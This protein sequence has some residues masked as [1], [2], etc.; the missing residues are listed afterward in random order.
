[1]GSHGHGRYNT[2][3]FKYPCEGTT[4][5]AINW[6]TAGRGIIHSECT[7]PQEKVKL[8]QAHGL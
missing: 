2:I 7:S 3:V 1:M 8:Q 4:P 5:G 6:M